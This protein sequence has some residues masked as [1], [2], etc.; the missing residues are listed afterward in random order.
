MPNDFVNAA[1]L[2][3]FQAKAEGRNRVVVYRMPAIEKIESIR[4]S[5]PVRSADERP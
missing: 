5:A 4:T 2:A 1:D 3:L